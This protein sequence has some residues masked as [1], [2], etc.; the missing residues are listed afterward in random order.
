MPYLLSV[1]ASQYVFYILLIVL[2]V[3]QYYD[4]WTTNKILSQGGTELNPVEEFCMKMLKNAW[5]LPKILIVIGPAIYLVYIH[6]LTTLILLT[7]LVIYYIW[8]VYHNFNQ[9]K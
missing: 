4:I 5:W 3:L 9:I 6:T 2:L 8:V 7:L 1:L